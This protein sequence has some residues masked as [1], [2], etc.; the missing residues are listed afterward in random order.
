MTLDEARE[1]LVKVLNTI[2]TNS[3][4]ACPPLTGALKPMEDLEGFD[5]KVWP[6]AIGMLAS[7]LNIEIADDVNIFT[8]GAGHAPLTID[9]SSA[10]ICKIAETTGKKEVAA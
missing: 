4:F 3:G 6:V 9:Q 2:Q 10:L 1:K 7:E 8:T 5:S